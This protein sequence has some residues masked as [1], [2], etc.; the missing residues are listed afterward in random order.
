MACSFISYQPGGDSKK[1]SPRA[2][3]QDPVQLASTTAHQP[4]HSPPNSNN[5]PNSF[6]FVD[7]ASAGSKGTAVDARRSIRR[8]ASK[9]CAAQR[10]ATLAARRKH[11]DVPT[12]R[13]RQKQAAEERLQAALRVH[14]AKL[15]EAEADEVVVRGGPSDPNWSYVATAEDSSTSD[16]WSR[17]TSSSSSLATVPSGSQ[18]QHSPPDLH[19][20]TTPLSIASQEVFSTRIDPFSTTLV[21][22]EHDGSLGPLFGLLDTSVFPLMD[23][24]LPLKYDRLY[25]TRFAHSRE[26]PHWVSRS[27]PLFWTMALCA[28]TIRTLHNRQRPGA[29][30]IT[31]GYRYMA[32]RSVNARIAAL[33]E[34]SVYDAALI[35]AIA[36]LGVWER[37]KGSKEAWHSHMQG[38]KMIMHKLQQESQSAML[39]IIVN[40]CQEPGS[41]P[42]EYHHSEGYRRIGDNGALDHRLLSPIYECGRIDT[43][44]P[45][46][47]RQTLVQ[48]T[49]TTILSYRPAD[50]VPRTLCGK[51]RNLD[52][53]R[54][55]LEMHVLLQAAAASLIHCITQH[56]ASEHV[57]LPTTPSVDEIDFPEMCRE[58]VALGRNV[59]TDPTY[60]DSLFWALFTIFALNE[61]DTLEGAELLATCA[62]NLGVVGWEGVQAS[63]RRTVYL[64]TVDGVYRRFFWRVLRPKLGLVQGGGG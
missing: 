13:E 3:H 20:S 62:R 64:E 14:A 34:D 19:Q 25:G 35:Y 55:Y 40:V 10:L 44:L 51:D 37:E 17:R 27:E 56:L 36:S 33:G 6:V 50:L 54:R 21:D 48:K 29:E 47:E 45:G 22:I 43:M 23:L 57:S 41:V 38:M 46:P 9:A 2:L 31:M 28:A 7:P 12:K 39:E 26:L 59:C 1:Q 42:I 8:H 24:R 49:A 18:L 52:G 4:R 53:D 63:L 16:D 5:I 60:D 58:M 15:A 32:I 61:Y 11:R 30:P